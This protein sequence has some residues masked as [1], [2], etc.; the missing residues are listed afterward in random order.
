LRTGEEGGEKKALTARA[1]GQRERKEGEGARAEEE[2]GLGRGP[3][4]R[5]RGEGRQAGLRGNWAGVERAREGEREGVW[6]GQA[7][8]LPFFS[9]SFSILKHSNKTI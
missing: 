7:S 6:A 1:S 8:L 4:G 9:F 5:E 3:C 2:I